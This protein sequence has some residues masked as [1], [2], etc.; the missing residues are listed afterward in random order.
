[1]H[2]RMLMR[3]L[4]AEPVLHT[5]HGPQ[6]GV[7]GRVGR[8]R[9]GA[10]GAEGRQGCRPGL[11]LAGGDHAVG[12]GAGGV[13]AHPLLKDDE[14]GDPHVTQGRRL[15][16]EVAGKRKV[17][18]SHDAFGYF[19]QAY[20][21]E[22]L[23]AQGTAEDAEPSARDLRLLIDQIRREGIKV[24]FL[25]NALSPRLAQQV[26]AETG[27]HIG[28]TLHADALSGPDGPAATYLG[29]IEHNAR[30]LTAAMLAAGDS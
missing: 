9:R 24:V 4:T 10:C 8:T 2:H 14:G 30:L 18:T 22:F 19:G 12:Q 25:E 26:A 16:Q 20:G 5:L 13:L 7:V 21:V 27:A 15:Y 29:M 23:A 28:G 11:A 6:V 1:M 17:V 3:Q